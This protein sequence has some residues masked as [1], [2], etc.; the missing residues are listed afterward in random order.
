MQRRRTET[1]SGSHCGT[2]VYVGLEN[3]DQLVGIDTLTNKVIGRSPIGQ[4]AQAIT[5]VPN[6]VPTGA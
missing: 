4:A 6:A 2:R 3:D 1:R 5:Y